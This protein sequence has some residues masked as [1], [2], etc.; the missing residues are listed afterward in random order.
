M[1]TDLI[2]GK[3]DIRKGGQSLRFDR[4]Q[5]SIAVEVFGAGAHLRRDVGNR[6]R[7][8]ADEDIEIELLSGLER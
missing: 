1:P 2:V 8:G 3:E 7:R 6:L 5:D 4:K